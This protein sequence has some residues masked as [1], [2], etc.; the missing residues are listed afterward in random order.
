MIDPPP[1]TASPADL[2]AVL[3]ELPRSPDYV[4]LK[5]FDLGE[6]V[7]RQGE[8]ATH[9][10]YILKGRVRTYVLSPDGKEKTFFIVGAGDVLND[11]DFYVQRPHATNAE[12]FERRVEV[13]QI[14]RAGFELIVQQ[15]PELNQFLLSNLAAKANWLAEEIMRQSFHDVR[16]RVQLTLIQLAQQHGML[17]AHGLAIDLR[18]THETIARLVGANRVTVSACLSDLQRDGFYQVI[19]Q[20]IV[21]A[22]WAIGQTLPP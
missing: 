5:H 2:Q 12:A 16:G 7:Y 20:R 1:S 11:A 9:L 6:C 8:A 19:D 18:I 3:A 21:L 14:G 17:T 15:H 10:F 22:P 13:Y 4:L